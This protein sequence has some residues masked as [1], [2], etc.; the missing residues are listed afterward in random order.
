MRRYISLGEIRL[1]TVMSFVNIEIS[2]LAD[3]CFGHVTHTYQCARNAYLSRLDASRR[4]IRSSMSRGKAS[5]SR[6]SEH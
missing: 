2:W 6:L 4:K 1:L 3:V 5:A